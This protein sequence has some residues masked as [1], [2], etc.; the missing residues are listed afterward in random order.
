MVVSLVKLKWILQ[1]CQKCLYSETPHDLSQNVGRPGQSEPA[2]TGAPMWMDGALMGALSSLPV[3]WL[4]KV[5]NSSSPFFFLSSAQVGF[6]WAGN[7]FFPHPSRLPRS[8]LPTYLQ[9]TAYVPWPPPTH[10]PTYPSTYLPINLFTYALNLHQGN[11][12]ASR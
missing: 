9:T 2:S 5:A 4:T 10:L 8:H 6:F 11:G 3:P 12:D 1:L 7:F